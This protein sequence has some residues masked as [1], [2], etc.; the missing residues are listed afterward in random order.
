MAIYKLLER[1]KGPL[2][3]LEDWWRLHVDDD[4]GVMTVEHEWSHTKINDLANPNNGSKFY[5]TADFLASDQR[6]E[7]KDRLEDVLREIGRS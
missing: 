7:A 6:Q 3:N 5:S 1:Q 4:T 2:Q